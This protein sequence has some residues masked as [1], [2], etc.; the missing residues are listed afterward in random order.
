M[1]PDYELYCWRGWPEEHNID[2]FL[3]LSSWTNWP[4]DELSGWG[5]VSLPGR[6]EPV[7]VSTRQA[8]KDEA[9]H[10]GRMTVC[11]LACPAAPPLTTPEVKY[12]PLYSMRA[13]EALP[14]YRRQNQGS[15]R[16]V[17]S[18]LTCLPAPTGQESPLMGGDMSQGPQWVPETTD[19]TKLL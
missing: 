19:R 3:P 16:L 9:G 14:S 15:E 5:T 18:G 10:A 8:G 2:L 1:T 6:A 17:V 11:T 7:P 13:G 12:C 4:R